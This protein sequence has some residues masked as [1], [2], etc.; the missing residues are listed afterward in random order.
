MIKR[1]HVRYRLRVD[2]DTDHEKIQRAYE[3][4]PARCPVYRSIHPQIACTTELEL[5]DD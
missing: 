2:A 3:H 4:H 1:I 5:V